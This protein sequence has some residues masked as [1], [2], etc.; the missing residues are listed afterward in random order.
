[1][2]ARRS[3]RTRA[4]TQ[5]LRASLRAVKA[6][7]IGHFG[8]EMMHLGAESVLPERSLASEEACVPGRT[9]NSER[10]PN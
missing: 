5:P 6:R 3:G 9:L 7:R 2:P 8:R 10:R 4:T 1:M